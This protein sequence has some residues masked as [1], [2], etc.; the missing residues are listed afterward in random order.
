M[1]TRAILFT[2]LAALL[3]PL[4]VQAQED[5]DERG[6]LL[7]IQTVEVMPEDVMAYESTMGMVV[8]AAELS[9]VSADFKWAI[10]NDN[11]T[12]TL[13]FPIKE[14][15]Y[16]DTPDQW[17]SQF[18]DTEGESTLQE[19]F[20]KFSEIDMRVVNT[21]I[22]EHVEDW[23]YTPAVELAEA[24]NAHIHSFR[25]KAG[26]AEAFGGVAKEIM[27]FFKELDY[28]Y[29]TAGHRTHFGDTGLA[30]FVIW[31]DDPGAFHGANDL[32]ALI[33]KKGMSDKWGELSGRL[34]KTITGA[35][36][37]DGVIKWNMTYWPEPDEAT[38]E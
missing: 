20:Q 37:S 22:V 14:F 18:K 33:E 26:Q 30:T 17:L 16:F 4:S 15:A 36:H 11:F 28:P 29:A 24:D 32:E 10:M 2:F 8:K 7:F 3:V 27:A 25:I 12:Y 23:S 13:V 19:A 35:Q 1:K 31:Y 6:Q 34:S 9:H 21:E 38:H 5:E